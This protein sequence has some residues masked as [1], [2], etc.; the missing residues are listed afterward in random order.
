MASPCQGKGRPRTFD[1]DAALSHALAVFWKHGYEPASIATLCDAMGLSAPSLYAA[2]GN[3][4]QLFIE[5]VRHYENL[6]WNAVWKQMETK[7][8][9]HKSV[10]DCFHRAARILTSQKISRGCIVIAG[11]TN[12]SPESQILNEELKALRLERR[13]RFSNRLKRGV[14]DGQLSPQT[15][16]EA[17]A[18]T[19]NAILEGMSNQARDGMTY[20]ELLG[21]ASTAMSL[22]PGYEN[23]LTRPEAL[24]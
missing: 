20:T 11:T 5:S 12:V 7:T 8:D 1:R 24:T 23:A 18:A 4:A 22:L 2:F 16:V 14:E 3:K 6:Y 13:R 17:L 19:L 10:H 15:N 21:I 9:L